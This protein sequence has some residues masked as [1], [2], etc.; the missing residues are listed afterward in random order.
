MQDS[1]VECIYLNEFDL[2]PGALIYFWYLK[3]G[4]LFETWRLS[5][6]GCLFLFEEHRN[7]Q[8]KRKSNK[9]KKGTITE[10]VTATD[11]R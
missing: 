10:T 2:A 5:G 7:V 3:E 4:R 1:I 9:T 11:I 8:N 6:T